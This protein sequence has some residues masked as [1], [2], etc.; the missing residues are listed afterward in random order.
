M[1]HHTK[2]EPKTRTQDNKNWTVIV[3]AFQNKNVIRTFAKKEL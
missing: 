3:D 2:M 1:L